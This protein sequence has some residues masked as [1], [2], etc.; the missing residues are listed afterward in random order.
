MSS[1]KPP[2]I[3]HCP[4]KGMFDHAIPHADY[5]KQEERERVSR[6]IQDRNDNHQNLR[7]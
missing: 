6:S 3:N 1:S 5:Q 7:T 4:A 2:N